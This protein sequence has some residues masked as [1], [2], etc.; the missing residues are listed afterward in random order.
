MGQRRQS[1]TNFLREMMSRVLTHTV[2]EAN[3][4]KKTLFVKELNNYVAFFVRDLYSLMPV[5]FVARLIHIYLHTTKN[6]PLML[7]F[8]KIVA[9]Y[10]HLLPLNLDTAQKHKFGPL[11][12]I[13][14]IISKATQ[15]I[16]AGGDP[17]ISEKA[18][19]L[20]R[21]LLVRFEYDAR[22]QAPEVKQLVADIFFPTV[23]VLVEKVDQIVAS[24]ALDDEVRGWLSIFMH[25]IQNS[26]PETRQ[27]CFV[28]NGETPKSTGVSMPEAYL[29]LLLRCVQLFECPSRDEKVTVKDMEGST[30]MDH[31]F[32]SEHIAN[33]FKDNQHSIEDK[34]QTM[35]Y[36][37]VTARRNT[38][39]AAGDGTLR[40]HK[41]R[42]RTMHGTT[43]AKDSSS[44]V[45][46]ADTVRKISK[47]ERNLCHEAYCIVLDAFHEMHEAHC[48][49]SLGGH[50]KNT[51]F[52]LII[53][54]L[55]RRTSASFRLSLLRYLGKSLDE[56]CHAL[57]SSP[58]SYCE[59]ITEHLVKGCNSNIEELRHEA[60]RVL[61]AL[62][63][64]NYAITG[65]INRIQMKTTVTVF[66]LSSKS[67][68][69]PE[70]F[71][72]HRSFNTIAQIAVQDRE[73]GGLQ[74]IPHGNQF[75]DVVK[76]V[77]N[78]LSEIIRD[79]CRVKQLARGKDAEQVADLWYRIAL[80]Y[81]DSPQL[82]I[83]SLK[84][85]Q[86][87]QK[88]KSHFAEAGEAAVHVAAIMCQ[89][90]KSKNG[91]CP[92][93]L[94]DFDHF[95]PPLDPDITATVVRDKSLAGEM[96]MNNDQLVEKLRDASN[97]LIEGDRFEAAIAIKHLEI[98][99]HE[100][101][102][103][104]EGLAA[105]YAEISESYRS[106][107]HVNAYESRMLGSYYRVCFHGE[108]FAELNRKTF[109]YKEPKITR[110]AEIQ[111]RLE[112]SFGH[113]LGCAVKTLSDS[114]A[115]K[116]LDLKND[117][118][119]QITSLQPYFDLAEE[120]SR[121]TYYERNTNVR[122]FVF[123]VPFTASGKAHAAS[124]AEQWKRRF[125]LTSEKPFPSMVTRSTVIETEEIELAPVENSID[126]IRTRCLLLLREVA[127]ADAE[128]S[129]P[130][131]E[132]K[133]D[134]VSKTLQQ[135]LQGSVLLQ[136][137]AGAKDIVASF[138]DPSA[139]TSNVD[140]SHIEQLR[141]LLFDFVDACKQALDR[142]YN[143][144]RDSS[145]Q[146]EFH[147]NLEEGFYELEGLI[148]GACGERDGDNSGNEMNSPHKD[149]LMKTVDLN[150]VN[151]SI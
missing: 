104:Y 59:D 43:S 87:F 81:K 108:K 76:D 7:T 25:L 127:K 100:D 3:R 126:T 149:S 4:S 83:E 13:K 8:L 125:I 79:T 131:R 140:K 117:C 137:N 89:L 57:F 94:Q 84:Q 88:E 116:S 30:T 27:A 109:I 49:S 128:L 28:F 21:Y 105:C 26:S 50:M 142:N 120:P 139:D 61:Y 63:K 46:E 55:G 72:L 101:K 2:K 122:R 45:V 48:F 96:D 56:M 16:S 69:N 19:A 123:E 80:G 62:M 22:Y 32:V 14:I 99:L 23:I 133:L 40:A 112:T 141:Q 97:L 20:L 44:T 52:T 53:E 86:E 146:R 106:I 75:F 121:T 34:Y 36:G 134:E 124:S 91:S 143:I 114:K 68:G 132:Q 10:E 93:K 151:M 150:D 64:A 129:K 41:T 51:Y 147:E 35:G 130:K 119:L 118:A 39:T 148:T 103:N 66:E 90:I 18:A 95:S 60:T 54:F 58:D 33:A 1:Q 11:W 73:A 37:S 70:T 113:S 111:E 67:E 6:V 9:S 138:F 42:T 29:K 145:K 17:K 144:I 115:V 65:D 110:L 102:R 135:V 77:S 31:S 71:P 136:V 47:W 92:L 15:Q 78:G 12:L 74:A 98:R 24:S 38:T 82:R 5:D 107:I 85:L